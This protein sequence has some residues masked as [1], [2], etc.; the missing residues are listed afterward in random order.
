MLSLKGLH[1]E[2]STNGEEGHTCLV[3]DVADRV[4]GLVVD[5]GNSDRHVVE[6]I[7]KKY[8]KKETN[9]I[10]SL[11]TIQF[12]CCKSPFFSFLFL[13]I[14]LIANFRAEST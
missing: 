10:L 11:S 9:D 3:V 6:A 12:T 5:V 1:R 2:I 14:S 4:L 13:F 7:K 8:G